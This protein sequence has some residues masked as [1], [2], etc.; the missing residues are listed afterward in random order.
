MLQKTSSRCNFLGIAAAFATT[1]AL[2]AQTVVLAAEDP[3]T[4]PDQAF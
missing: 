3:I 4:N 1:A 2:G